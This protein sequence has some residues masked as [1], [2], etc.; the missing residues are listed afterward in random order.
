LARILNALNHGLARRLLTAPN[1]NQKKYLDILDL[2]E[3]LKNMK[4]ENTTT[5]DTADIQDTDSFLAMCSYAG[6]I[7]FVLDEEEESFDG[8]YELFGQYEN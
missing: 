3:Y 1:K 2:I 4:N 7:P 5:A 8:R 6:N